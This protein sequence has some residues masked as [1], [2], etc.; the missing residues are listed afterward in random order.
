MLSLVG[1]GKELAGTV[2]LHPGNLLHAID[3]FTSQCGER[4]GRSSFSRPPKT[5][6]LYAYSWQGKVD[7]FIYLGWRKNG[8]AQFFST[9]ITTCIRLMLYLFRVGKEWAGPV[10]PHPLNEWPAQCFS[11]HITIYTRLMLYLFRVG[12]EWAGPILPNPLKSNGSMHIH[13]RVRL[14]LS[15]VRVGKE[16]TSLVILHPDNYLHKVDALSCQSGQRMG[17]TSFSPPVKTTLPCHEYT[18]NLC[19]LEDGEKLGR[20]ILSSLWQDKAST[21]YRWLSGWRK[22]RLAHSSP[23]STSESINLTLSWI[24][25][26]PWLFRVSGWGKNGLAQF[27]STWII[28]CTRLMFFT[29]PGGERKGRPSFSPSPKS[30]GCTHVHNR[31][32]LIDAFT[33]CSDYFTILCL[34]VLDTH[35]ILDQWDLP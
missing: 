31:V 19:F 29:F 21:L 24:C 9:Q 3:A 35:W 5:Q 10:L 23:I 15:L 34:W 4:M 16:L 2:F 20:P 33:S 8:P 14:M 1:V 11:T 26:Q 13:D 17:R 32:K 22:T 12:K 6:W 28:I 7:A 27:Y 25:I 18:Y 30:K